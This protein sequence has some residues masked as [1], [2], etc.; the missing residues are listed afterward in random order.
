MRC[1]I[2]IAKFRDILSQIESGHAFTTT[3]DSFA[4]SGVGEDIGFIP[5][6]KI[7]LCPRWKKC[8]A[9]F[10]K[11]HAVV[12]Q[13]ARR[14]FVTQCVQMKHVRGSIFQLCLRQG[15]SGPICLLLR[16]GNIDLQQ[17]FRLS[18]RPCRSV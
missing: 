2:R 17:F 11:L 18:L 1:G 10:G 4:R 15:L 9:G 8:E 6:E 14:Q 7:Q 3:P 5:A 16:L 12:A 13:Q